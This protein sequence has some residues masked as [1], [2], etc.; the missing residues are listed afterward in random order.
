MDA[1]DDERSSTLINSSPMTISAAP[2]HQVNDRFSPN[3]SQPLNAYT[4]HNNHS[5]HTQCHYTAIWLPDTA[6]PSQEDHYIE[7][8]CEDI[9]QVFIHE[10]LTKYCHYYHC[11]RNG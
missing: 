1:V 3:N 11:A 4:V 7:Q 6:R 5:V 8:T 9:K 10:I 2:H